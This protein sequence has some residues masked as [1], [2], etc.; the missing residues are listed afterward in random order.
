MGRNG[1]Q[2]FQRKHLKP[3]RKT[4]YKQKQNKKLQ[5]KQKKSTRKTKIQDAKNEFLKCKEKA[6]VSAQQVVSADIIGYGQTR[7]AICKLANPEE[8]C[9]VRRACGRLAKLQKINSK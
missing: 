5:P 3:E 8:K 9:V 1:P 6:P 2:S 7:P 4:S